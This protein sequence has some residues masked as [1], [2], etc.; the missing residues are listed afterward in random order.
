MAPLD[1]CCPAARCWLSA[2]RDGEAGEQPEL[3]AHVRSCTE[4]QRWDAATD[5]LTRRAR[6]HR[7]GSPDVAAAAL[8]VFQ[9]R[10]RRRPLS[11]YARWILG[12]AGVTGLILAAFGLVASPGAIS[13]PGLHLGHD[14]YSFETALAF[15][16]LLTAFRPDRYGRGLLA[17]TATVAL[18]TL[19][20]SVAFLA[21]E[22]RDLLREVSHLPMLIGLIGLL[23]LAADQRR[24]ARR[25]APA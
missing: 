1:V 9:A 15:G 18:L 10:G 12:F 14:L 5:A 8:R 3:R 7:I 23:L 24:L 2:L 6:V 13:E 19:L 11:G 17:V 25:W 4:C 22:H 16:F 20:P 21:S